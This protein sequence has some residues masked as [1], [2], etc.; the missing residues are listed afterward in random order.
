MPVLN[1]PQKKIPPKKLTTRMLN[2]EYF[3][4]GRRSIAKS[5]GLS[6]S[7]MKLSPMPSMIFEGAC[8]KGARAPLSFGRSVSDQ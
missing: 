6:L 5:P 3:A 1:P 2:S 4:L 8:D 7:A